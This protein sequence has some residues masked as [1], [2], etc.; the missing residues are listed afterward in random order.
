ME[1]WGGITF[2]ESGLLYDPAASSIESQRRI[3]TLLAHEIAHQWFGNLVTMAWWNDLWLNEG[4]ASWMQ[5]KA[6]EA[7]HPDWQPWLNANGS[8]QSA[9][10]RDAQRTARAI[11]QPVANETEARAVFDTITYSK[12]Q[13]V[14]RMIESYLGDDVFRDAMRRYMKRPCLQQRHDRRSLARA[15]GRVRQGGRRGGVDLH[16]TS[17]AFRSSSPRPSAATTQQRIRSSRSASPCAIPTPSR[18][19][20]RCRS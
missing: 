11:Q 19:A 16:A 6:G 15:R 17:P 20:G 4:F 13:A 7:L 14:V 9:M 8:K 1:H 12:G 5:Y 18:S 2:F 10:A 3:F